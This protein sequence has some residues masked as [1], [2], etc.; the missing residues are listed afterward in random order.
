MIVSQISVV[1]VKIAMGFDLRR[2]YC[3]GYIGGR[4]LGPG[5]L[6]ALLG[7]WRVSGMV[8]LWTMRIW[9]LYD[10]AFWVLRSWY[11]RFPESVLIFCWL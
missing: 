1:G 2:R 7:S 10:E 11:V 8:Q 5:F 9:G 4:V 3:R 6:C